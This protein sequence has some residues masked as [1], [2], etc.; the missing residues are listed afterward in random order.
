MPNVPSLPGVPPLQ[1]TQ[2]SITA[3][4]ILAADAVNFTNNLFGVTQWGIYQNGV[5]V[6]KPDSIVDFGYN[7][8]Y[9]VSN[10]QVEEGGFQSYDKV[11]LPFEARIR[12]AIGSGGGLSI[13]STGYFKKQQFLTILE[14]IAGTTN[15][16]DIHTPDAIYYSANITR[17]GYD[18]SAQRGA[19]LLVVDV[20]FLEVRVSATQQFSN[21]QTPSGAN[22]TNGGQAALTAP[23]STQAATTST[24]TGNQ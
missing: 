6:I 20:F 15:L 10:Y 14:S 22:P 7:H 17:L 9:N 1:G 3:P 12:M 13:L 8:A 16:Y 4:I 23:T 11:Q 5:L 2:V 24:I 18:R 21:T 19:T